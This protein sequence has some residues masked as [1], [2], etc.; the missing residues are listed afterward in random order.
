M[1]EGAHAC[2]G[3][4]GKRSIERKQKKNNHCLVLLFL[5]PFH[6]DAR[7]SVSTRTPSPH[8]MKPALLALTLAA[9]AATA[10]RA[11]V[12]NAP[13]ALTVEG[14]GCRGLE[15]GGTGSKY[16]YDVRLASV[17]AGPLCSRS[18]VK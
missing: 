8:T 12:V 6:G 16:G 1:G 5:A 13:A 17:E 14:R 4:G 3:G 2:F 9:A 11:A 10:T 7:P 18:M 15:I